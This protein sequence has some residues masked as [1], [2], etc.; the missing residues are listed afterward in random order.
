MSTATQ[1]EQEKKGSLRSTLE[2]LSV[3]PEVA[4][5]RKAKATGEDPKGPNSLSPSSRLPIR[6]RPG[7]ML[8]LEFIM[9]QCPKIGLQCRFVVLALTPANSMS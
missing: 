1:Q 8:D 9:S 3:R 4:V 5:A 6:M 7:S 2:L